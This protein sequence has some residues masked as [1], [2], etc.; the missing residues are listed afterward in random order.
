MAALDLEL[1]VVSPRMPEI[2]LGIGMGFGLSFSSNSIV[3]VIPAVSKKI[4]TAPNIKALMNH[5]KVNFSKP[6]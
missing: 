3:Y 4:H 1:L 6:L 2:I 5:L